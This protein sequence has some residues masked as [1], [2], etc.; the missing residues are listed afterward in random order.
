MNFPRNSRPW[1]KGAGGVMRNNGNTRETRQRKVIYE[2]VRGSKSHPTADMIFDQVR[3]TL[4]T[5]SLG[6]VYRNLNVLKDQGLVIELR[7]TDRRAHFEADLSP[8]A[9]FTCTRCGSILDIQHCPM[10]DWERHNCLDGFTLEKFSLE[11]SG[12]CPGCNA[13]LE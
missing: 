11:F 13:C 9:H 5:V 6:T 10:P 7:G 1:Y 4:P 12:I 3:G 8:H 2:A